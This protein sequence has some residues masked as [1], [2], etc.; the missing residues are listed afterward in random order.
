LRRGRV[1]GSDVAIGCV[2]LAALVVAFALVL[3]PPASSD[4]WARAHTAQ[5]RAYREAAASAA[6]QHD[7][8]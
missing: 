2:G 4:A 1:R 6:R 5:L 7:G 3:H 8:E